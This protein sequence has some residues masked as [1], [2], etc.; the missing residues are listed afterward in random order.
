V[1]S[2]IATNDTTPTIE[3]IKSQYSKP[4]KYRTLTSS[5]MIYQP[6]TSHLK[7]KYDMTLFTSDTSIDPQNRDKIMF[8]DGSMLLVN[9]VLPQKQA[10][11]YMFRKK[12]PVIL[13]L[14]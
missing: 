1:N 13:E 5:E 3:T 10:G 2:L 12:F 14:A 11:F 7:G 9:K 4:F 6:I 8:E